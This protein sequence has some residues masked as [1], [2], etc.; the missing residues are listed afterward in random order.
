M[1]KTFFLIVTVET[2]QKSPMLKNYKCEQ[3]FTNWNV[4]LWA[5]FALNVNDDHSSVGTYQTYLPY[6]HSKEKYFAAR[7]QAEESKVRCSHKTPSYC[8]N[9]LYIL[10]GQVRWQRLL[11]S[12]SFMHIF[13]SLQIGLK[14]NIWDES[15]FNA[16]HTLLTF[17]PKTNDVWQAELNETVL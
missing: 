14:W 13:H 11:S 4:F 10:L 1:F 6:K 3:N 9:I 17:F 8:S 7:K 12:A 2:G 16:E 15:T 5:L